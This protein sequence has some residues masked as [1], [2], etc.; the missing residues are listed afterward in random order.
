MIYK[1]LI[2]MGPSHFKTY[3]TAGKQP[4]GSFRRSDFDVLGRH[5]WARLAKCST[6]CLKRPYVLSNVCLPR[7]EHTKQNGVERILCTP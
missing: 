4:L 6:A 2:S 3:N 1:N 7:L 5:P